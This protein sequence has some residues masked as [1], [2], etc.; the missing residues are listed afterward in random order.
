MA[1][2]PPVVAA[3]PPQ[4]VTSTLCS[5]SFDRDLKR[6]ARV[7]NEGKACLD[8]LA[9]SLQRST[10]SKLYIIGNATGKEKEMPKGRHAKAPADLAAE[11]AVDTKAYLVSEKGIDA[12]RIVVGTGSDD[13]K[14][15]TDI[16]VPAGAT[17]PTMTPVDESAVKAIPRKALPAKHHK[18][19]S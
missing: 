5:I 19:A 8:D 15:V 12:S 14:S 3:P 1:P 11:R 4:P 16:L 6:P 13:S 7:D 18:K 9:L 10:D 17:P 2:P